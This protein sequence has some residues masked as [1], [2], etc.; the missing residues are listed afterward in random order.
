MRISTS[1]VAWLI[2]GGVLSISTPSAVR[3]QGSS[4]GSVSVAG[5]I[6]PRTYTSKLD[7]LAIG[8]FQEYRDLRAYQKTSPLFE[9]L[10]AKYAPADSFGFYNISARKLFDRDQ[11]IGLLA[12]CQPDHTKSRKLDSQV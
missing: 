3:A 5:E 1:S 11:S 9:Q 4:G 7:S 2:A 12:H 10:F 8:K 6:G